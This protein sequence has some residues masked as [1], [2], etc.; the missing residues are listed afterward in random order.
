M[1]VLADEVAV[2]VDY[3]N[4]CP[5]LELFFTKEKAEKI[6]DTMRGDCRIDVL[7]VHVNGSGPIEPMLAN[8][9]IKTSEH[10]GERIFVLR[11]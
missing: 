8:G 4:N 1:F 11:S 6:A 5:H 10:N 9:V 3:A 2:L 7:P